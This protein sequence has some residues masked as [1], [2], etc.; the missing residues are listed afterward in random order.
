[1]DIL[2][3]GMVVWVGK[4]PRLKAYHYLT[5]N[6]FVVGRAICFEDAVPY[7]KGLGLNVAEHWKESMRAKGYLGVYNCEYHPLSAADYA[8]GI[9]KI[10]P[11]VEK[12]FTQGMNNKVFSSLL[13]KGDE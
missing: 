4:D 8:A 7:L 1:M 3:Q 13:K 10:S 12:I 5:Y 6:P 2:K 9:V 11:V